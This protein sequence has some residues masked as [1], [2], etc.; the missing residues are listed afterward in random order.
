MYFREQDK[1]RVQIA[2]TETIFTPTMCFASGKP[3]LRE[4]LLI[5]SHIKI[6]QKHL[7][8]ILTVKAGFNKKALLVIPFL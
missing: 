2:I 4:Y 3:T 7:I 1:R 6:I 5:I 8:G